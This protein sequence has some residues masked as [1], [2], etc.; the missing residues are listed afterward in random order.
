V[1]DVMIPK[2]CLVAIFMLEQ[3]VEQNGVLVS[4]PPEGWILGLILN[5]TDGCRNIAN[6][7]LH[8]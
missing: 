7:F 5:S 8:V 4:G 3:E 2:Q 6:W 1:T